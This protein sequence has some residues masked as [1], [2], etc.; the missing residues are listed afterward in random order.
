[1]KRDGDRWSRRVKATA[2]DLKL[3]YSLPVDDFLLPLDSP[4]LIA[5]LDKMPETDD[6][7]TSRS[8]WIPKHKVAFVELGFPDRV[9]LN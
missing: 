6:E 5:I 7:G 4:E 3:K 2:M 8:G 9:N 1:M